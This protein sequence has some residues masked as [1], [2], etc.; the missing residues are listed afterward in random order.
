[1]ESTTG[2]NFS[3]KKTASQKEMSLETLKNLEKVLKRRFENLVKV[4]PFDLKSKKTKRIT[5]AGKIHDSIPVV[6][7]ERRISSLQCTA[8]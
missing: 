4:K 7:E 3:L 6:V 5:S 1:M 8:T 2:V